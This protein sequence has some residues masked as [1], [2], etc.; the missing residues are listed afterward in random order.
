MDPYI[1]A[2]RRH[3]V[4]PL[5]GKDEKRVKILAEKFFPLTS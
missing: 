3:K 2:L 4:E 5:I 1:L